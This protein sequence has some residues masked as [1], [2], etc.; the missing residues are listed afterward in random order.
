M[1]SALGSRPLFWLHMGLS[2]RGAADLIYF[3]IPPCSGRSRFCSTYLRYCTEEYRPLSDSAVHV[4]LP[5]NQ[6]HVRFFL[7]QDTD[8]A[9]QRAERWSSAIVDSRLGDWHLPKAFCA[10]STIPLR[11]DE[12][13]A[14]RR[15]ASTIF[16]WRWR[17]SRF[18]RRLSRAVGSGNG[19]ITFFPPG[20]VRAGLVRNGAPGN[21]I[22]TVAALVAECEH[23]VVVPRVV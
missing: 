5:C 1:L 20:C 3:G 8:V 22:V 12:R 21:R 4:V 11:E 18:Y 10:H 13:P 23:H 14:G 6:M 17:R 9:W 15:D 19:S 2:I 7:L 16:A